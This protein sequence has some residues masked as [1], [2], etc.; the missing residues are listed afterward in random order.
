MMNWKAVGIKWPQTVHRER[1]VH[2]SVQFRVRTESPD[3]RALRSNVNALNA[4]VA[5]SET[6]YRVSAL[7]LPDF[8]V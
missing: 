5:T 6:V 1:R 4:V 2:S 8:I 3:C 7:R